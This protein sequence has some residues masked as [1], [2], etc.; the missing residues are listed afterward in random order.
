MRQ[1]RCTDVQATREALT[2]RKTQ[3]ALTAANLYY[4]QDLTMEAIAD[5]MHTSRSSVSRL[6]G[7]ARQTG[8]V[9][10][11]IRSPDESVPRLRTEVD[12]RFGIAS[13]IVPVPANVSEVDRLERV[14]TVAARTLDR[15][16]DS[17]MTVGIA[18][19][20]TMS[21]VS[22]HLVPRKL[23][24]VEVVQ[25]NGAGNQ[26]TTGVVY[27]SELLRRF[28]EAFSAVTH[29]FPVPALFDDPLTRE[30]MWRER[31]IKHIL[32]VQHR[33]DLAIFGLGTPFSEVPSHVYSG[34]YLSAEDY[35]ALEAAHVVGDVATVFFRED[36]S[37]NDIPLNARASGPGVSAI[38]R[39]ARRVCIVAGPAK[40]VS[41][42]G[43]LAAGLITDLIVDEA[44][45]FALL[46][47][48]GA[49]TP[50]PRTR[51]RRRPALA[52]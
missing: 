6:I 42:R 26:Y 20:T 18:W 35:E 5:E 37:W 36:G 1:A 47:S 46:E 10:I 32:D 33:M 4:M 41:L 51:G 25:L 43:A 24:S 23:H 50:R 29:E 49:V 40:V 13:H 52:R 48:V 17:G 39:T 3:D 16:V 9:T 30:A 38:K 31:S 22:R 34:G 7:Y 44:T 27:A 2:D 28:G 21:A 8:L 11:A 12:E 19:G 45:A 15:F 14:A